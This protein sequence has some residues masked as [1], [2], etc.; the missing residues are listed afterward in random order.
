VT[1]L[2]LATRGSDLAL[3]QSSWVA[4]RVEAALGVTVEIQK[5]RTSGDRLAE[6]SLAEHGGKG[7]FVKEI[8]EALLE[9]RADFAVH[10][11]KDLP[12]RV[13]DGLRLAAFPERAD[14][15]D[16]LL[17]AGRWT[18]LRD[19]PPGTVVG[20][21]SVRR[22]M[23]LHSRFP[24][25]Q[26]RPLRGNVPTRIRKMESGA[27]EALILACAGVD[28]LGLGAQ[29][30]ERIDPSTMLP[31]VG[32]G[33]LALQTRGGE[34]LGDAL[35]A[36]CHPNAA[37]ALRAERAF[38]VG[39]EGDCNVPLAAFAQPDARDSDAGDPLH[40]EGRNRGPGLWLRGALGLPDGSR[41]E[42][43]ELR[44]DHPEELGAEA[45]RHILERGGEEILAELRAGG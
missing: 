24:R 3:A 31:A 15:R 5:I 30:D 32:Q 21:G 20:T 10:S 19:L 8:E 42:E 26:V 25:L 27:C 22:G 7:L 45:A 34:A 17:S 18:R 23:W 38:L 41:I 2:R 9:G 11:A 39:L 13:P 29:I 44:G 14:P 43:V 36:L 4:K 6:V 35:A 12:A 16:A 28:R 37:R 1:T 40:P 33:V